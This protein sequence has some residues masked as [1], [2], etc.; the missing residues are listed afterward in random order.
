VIAFFGI[1]ATVTIG[2]EIEVLCDSCFF[3]CGTIS[4]IHFESESRLRRIERLAFGEC[5]SLHTI[6]IP[7]S[8]QSLEPEWFLDSHHYGG[9][10]FDTVQFESAESLSNMLIGGCVDL[11]GGFNIEV[12][13]WTGDPPIPGYCPGTMISH[14]CIRLMKYPEPLI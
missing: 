10:V 12:V 3:R 11:S 8:I 1:V 13:N 7:A 6:R 2:R 14:D 9:V 4:R 5:R